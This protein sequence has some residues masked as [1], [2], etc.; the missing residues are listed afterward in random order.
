MCKD[1]FKVREIENKMD[2]EPF[3]SASVPLPALG[4][5]EE[6]SVEK[7]AVPHKHPFPSRLRGSAVTGACAFQSF[8]KLPCGLGQVNALLDFSLPSCRI[9]T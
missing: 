7:E 3:A 8:T 9:R 5:E 4:P 2:L 1:D 6:S